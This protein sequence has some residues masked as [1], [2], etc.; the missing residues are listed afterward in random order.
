MY[1]NDITNIKSQYFIFLLTTIPYII[2]KPQ[3]IIIKYPF[4]V[5]IMTFPDLLNYF[6]KKYIYTVVQ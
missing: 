6:L 2:I 4:I 5:N 1:Y 3:N